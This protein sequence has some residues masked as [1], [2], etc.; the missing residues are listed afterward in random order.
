MRGVIIL[1]QACLLVRL[2]SRVFT[3]H[4]V[5]TTML[6]R[7]NSPS[8]FVDYHVAPEKQP[9]PLRVTDAVIVKYN[10]RYFCLSKLPHVEDW[11]YVNL[12][13]VERA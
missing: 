11:T 13:F 6:P 12:V 4:L 10:F 9:E 3:P 2:Y 5:R 1:L 7:K 8:R